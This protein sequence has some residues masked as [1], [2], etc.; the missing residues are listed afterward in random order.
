MFLETT[1]L[2]SLRHEKEITHRRTEGG[3]RVAGENDHYQ[4]IVISKT[5]KNS[6]VVVCKTRT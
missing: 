4:L 3:N 6:D 5:A 1:L 2:R